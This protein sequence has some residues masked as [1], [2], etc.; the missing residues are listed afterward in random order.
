MS[1]NQKMQFKIHRNMAHNSKEIV[2][3]VQEVA[4][5]YMVKGGGMPLFCPTM[6]EAREAI[7]EAL[8]QFAAV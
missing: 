7:V 1:K 6:D 4:N 3:R 8:A 5:G 2:F